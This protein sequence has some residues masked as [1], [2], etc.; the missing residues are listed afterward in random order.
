ME[1]FKWVK[2]SLFLIPLLHFTAANR[3]FLLSSTV[4]DGDE[5]TLSCENVR[6]DQNNCDGTTWTFSYLSNRTVELVRLGQIG[7]DAKTKSDRLSVR[8][9]CSLVI[10]N[11]TE[12]D[13]GRYYCQ[14]YNKAEQHQGQDSQVYLSVVTMT[15]EKNDDIVTLNCS[16]STYE[17]CKHTV[18]WPYEGK[19]VA[20]DHPNIETLQRGCYTTVKWQDPVDSVDPGLIHKPRSNLLKCEVTDGYTEEVQLFPFIPPHSS[21]EKPGKAITATSETTRTSDKSPESVPTTTAISDPSTKLQAADATTRTTISPTSETMSTSEDWWRWWWLIVVSVAVAALIIITV[22]VLRWR[23]AKGNKTQTEVENMADPE[24]GVSYASISYTKK[25][26]RRAQA[27]GGDDDEDDAVTYSTVKAPS[28]SA[29]ASA[30]LSN[31]YATVNKPN[32]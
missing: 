28:S 13:V 14:Q 9:N 1:E 17:R 18:K 30:D 6:D 20:K 27:R 22:A 3:Q 19:D 2:M 10:K 23:R 21:R 12:E 16:V 8:E 11:V 4:R 31:L 15:E 7:V 25:T 24:D 5:V 32:K 26:N 29:A